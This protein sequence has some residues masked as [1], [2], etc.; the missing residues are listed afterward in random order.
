MSCTMSL[1]IQCVSASSF[2]DR[3]RI[4]DPK[5]HRACRLGV[6]FPGF[7]EPSSE[8]RASGCRAVRVISEWMASSL[9]F[10]VFWRVVVKLCLKAT[11][12]GEINGGNNFGNAAARF[13]SM[14]QLR[15]DSGISPNR[16]EWRRGVYPPT[17][18]NAVFIGLLRIGQNVKRFLNINVM[19]IFEWLYLGFRTF[20]RHY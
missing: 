12:T 10:H 5:L 3:F 13:Y 17:S 11:R 16:K 14:F 9:H 6:C 4:W 19:V 15:W 1:P 2:I 18:T 7:S 8:S 20:V